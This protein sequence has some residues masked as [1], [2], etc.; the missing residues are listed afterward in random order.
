MPAAVGHFQTKNCY[1]INEFSDSETRNHFRH[2]ECWDS[3]ASEHPSNNSLCGNRIRHQECIDSIAFVFPNNNFVCRLTIVS[4]LPRFQSFCI[5]KIKFQHL[6]KTC[7]FQTNNCCEIDSF[8]DS[9]AK[10]IS[11]IQNAEI[12]QLLNIQATVRFVRKG[13]DIKNAQIP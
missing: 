8:S 6:N 10:T 3:V 12:L 9:E 7:H 1:E 2:P 11:D 5:S 13:L 4:F